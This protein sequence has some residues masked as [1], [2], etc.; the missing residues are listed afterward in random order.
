MNFHI[1]IYIYVIL[2]LYI[3]RL[4]VKGLDLNDY[5]IL[6]SSVHAYICAHGSRIYLTTC[7]D[8]LDSRCLVMVHTCV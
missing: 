3:V 6:R 7:G 8:F 5:V 2:I 4:V 1:Y